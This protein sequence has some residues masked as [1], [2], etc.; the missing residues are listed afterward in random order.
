MKNRLKN[1]LKHG[2]EPSKILELKG[3]LLLVG[4]EGGGWV[5][6]PTEA[7]GALLQRRTIESNN[8]KNDNNEA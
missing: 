2:K 4:V 8:N 3:S 5:W 7:L 1:V 6:L